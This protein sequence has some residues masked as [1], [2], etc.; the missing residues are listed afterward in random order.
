[1][2]RHHSHTC[3]PA[4][5]ATHGAP[6]A[7]PTL[8]PPAAPEPA[9]PPRPL[10]PTQVSTYINCPAQWWYRYALELPTPTTSAQAVGR[11]IHRAIAATHYARHVGASDADLAQ[12]GAAIAAE[13][14]A[15]ATLAADEDPAALTAQALSLAALYRRQALSHMHIAAIETPLTGEIAGVPVCGI[16]DITTEAGMVIDLKTSNRRPSGLRPAHQL[17]LTTYAM[18]SG[19]TQARLDTLV[20]TNTP[21]LIHH[22]HTVDAQAIRYAESLY[23]IA[24]DGTKSGHYPPRRDNNLCS[25]KHC[26]YWSLCEREYGGTVA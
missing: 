13:E 7:C 15:A 18:L 3:R 14:L 1:M 26:P 20:R 12:I 17:Q 11:I 10:S 22:T 5:L 16:A 23:Q 4:V 2:L 9:A 19:T 8:P 21:A 25:R 6:G 24:A